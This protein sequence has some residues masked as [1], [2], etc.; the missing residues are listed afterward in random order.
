MILF[1]DWTGQRYITKLYLK[2]TGVL[3]TGD[4]IENYNKSNNIIRDKA[5]YKLYQLVDSFN[6]PCIEIGCMNFES[7]IYKDEI[8]YKSKM[9]Q[10]ERH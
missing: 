3:S 9:K 1:I 10:G 8:E 5:Q 6:D 7:Q 2:R 4:S